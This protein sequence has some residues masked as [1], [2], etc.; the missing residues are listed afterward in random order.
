MTSDLSRRG[1]IAAGAG[2]LAVCA[3]PARAQSAPVAE[4]AA[5][6]VQGYREGGVVVFK[7]VRY[8]A[9]TGGAG[10]F[11]PPRRPEPWAGVKEAAAYGASSPQTTGGPGSP[12]TG[13]AAGAAHAIGDEDCLFLNVWTPALDG[14]KRPVM[15]WLHGGGFATG[16]GSSPWYDGAAQARNNDVVVVTINHRLNVFGYCYLGELGGERFADSAA[17]GML[18]VVQSLE[19]VRDNIERFG[20][21]PRT[22]MIFGESGG[23]RKVSLMMGFEPAGGLFHR[24]AVESGSAI[25]MDSR[26]VGTERSEKLLAALGIPKTDLDRLVS[27]PTADLA[28]A[29]AAATRA[30]GQFRPVVDG[31]SVK[32]HPFDPVGPAMTK[33]VP[34]L[35]GTNRTEAS[36]MLGFTPGIGDLDQ[37]GLRQRVGRLVP[38]GKTDEVLAM[39]ARLYPASKPDEVL[40]MAQT[41]RSYFLDA[42]IQAG[43]KA[44]QGGAPAFMYSFYRRTPVATGRLFTPHA[45]EIAFVFD[46]LDKA[47]SIVG[48]VTPQ[49][50]ALAKNMSTA[51]A[52]FARTGAPAA[53]GLPAWPT[54]DSRMRRTMI[55]NYESHVENDPRGEQR[56]LML[57][58]GS[59]QYADH[60]TS[61][62]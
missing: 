32:R 61:P 37:A 62:L 3:L 14:R 35:I 38:E 15:V 10:R 23:G 53:P 27:T 6:K 51:W 20:G 13:G 26:A 18:D 54:Y 9:S 34:M 24:A 58:F 11:Q 8:G 31:R 36:F 49:M 1:A 4:T 17:V 40:Y 45:S 46:T 5:G 22:V 2:L 60:E 30:T 21:D 39:Y 12:L 52:T 25:R 19:W 44:D 42:T 43:R 59:Q 28:M 29:V 16:S 56:K 41:D 48:P 33:N 55:L 47:G 7:G 57:S 50:Q